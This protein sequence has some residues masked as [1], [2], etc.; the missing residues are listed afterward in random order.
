MSNVIEKTWQE[1]PQSDGRE[2]KLSRDLRIS[3]ITAK[4]LLN[5]GITDSI[6]AVAF[7]KPSLKWLSSPFLLHQMEA[8]SEILSEHIIQG[9]KIA[10]YGDYDVDGLTGTAVLFSFLKQLGAQVI[11]Y[12]P[13]RLTEGYG[14]NISAINLLKSKGINLIVTVDCGITN[15]S[16]V[17]HAK[18]EGLKIIVTDHHEIPDL[19]LPADAVVNPK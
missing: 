1:P 14:L 18:S 9:K 10:I 17:L 19:S 16:E 5:R 13:K 6:S 4:I 8:A 12:I 3:E 7:L 15:Y 2:K 11:Y